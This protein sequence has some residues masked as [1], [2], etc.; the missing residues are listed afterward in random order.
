MIQDD[1]LQ[2]TGCRDGSKPH[3]ISGD[4]HQF[5]VFVP[6]SHVANLAEPRLPGPLMNVKSPPAKQSGPEGRGCCPFS[7]EPF[8]RAPFF[9]EEPEIT[10]QI[11]HSNSRRPVFGC[12]AGGSM[13]G[14]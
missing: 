1:A 9:V 8:F 3:Q 7:Q 5:Q 13:A 10:C 2:D 11:F 12:L 6:Y 14:W 4:E